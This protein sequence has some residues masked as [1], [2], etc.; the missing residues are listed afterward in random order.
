MGLRA[1]MQNVGMGGILPRAEKWLDGGWVPVQAPRGQCGQ[2]GKGAG[3]WRQ[4]QSRVTCGQVHGLSS[5]ASSLGGLVILLWG[6]AGKA[7]RAEVVGITGRIGVYPA[8]AWT[9]WV[10]A[11]ALQSSPSTS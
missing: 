4:P 11:A 1:V 10:P 2:D 9:G 7:E 6:D 8:K 3:S 5:A